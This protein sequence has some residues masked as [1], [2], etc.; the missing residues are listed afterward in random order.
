LDFGPE[1]LT[2]G[3]ASL[4]PPK[5]GAS[6]VTL[7]P[8]V[9]SDGNEMSGVVLPELRAPLATYTGWNLRDPKIG[10]PEGM[11][12]LQ[13]SM[14]PFAQTKAAREKSGDPRPSIEERYKD[15]G[16]YLRKI[17][18]VARQLAGQRL[19][20]ERDVPLVIARARARWESMVAPAAV[21]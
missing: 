10:A 3:I 7:V 16:E 8:Q 19:L 20:L 11:Y 1:F 13:G 18:G 15:Q 6:F 21:K 5:E 14:I 2:K 4:E 12:A 9:N 17:E